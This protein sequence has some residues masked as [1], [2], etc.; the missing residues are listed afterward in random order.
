MSVF[1]SQSLR[2]RLM[3]P[4]SIVVVAIIALIS[5]VL[6]VS[7]KRSFNTVSAS[8][9]TQADVVKS[10][11]QEDL[12]GVG[13]RE[14]QR[15]EASL[16]TKA[17][18]MAS[19]VA[20][21]APT[22]ILTFDFD[23]LDNYCRALASDPDILLAHVVNMEG[24]TLTSFRNEQDEALRALVSDIDTLS[25]NQVVAALG[26]NDSAFSVRQQINQDDVPL[27]H[28]ELFVSREG[29]REQ[30]AITNE[31][32]GNIV[33]KVD[34]A[35][36]TL[37]KGVEDQVRKS[38]LN[39]AWQAVAAGIVGI[40]ILTLSVAFLIDR[41]IIKPV[42][43]VMHIIGEMA[44]GHL[45]ERLQLRR[46]D[47]IGRMSDSIDTL[48][49]TLE[50]E[51]LGSLSKLADGDLRF[52]VSPKDG[53]DALGNALQKMS[54]NLTTTIQQIQQNASV[55]ASSSEEMSA[56]SSELAASSEQ[57]TAQAANV[58]AST[59]EIN[60]S[61]HDIK[62]IAE[63]MSQNMQRLAD[64]TKRIADEVDE[65]G[66][67]AKEGSNI[68]GKAL[69]MVNNANSIILSL[70]EAAGQIGITTATIEEITEQT[71]L[72][73]L[74]ATIEAARAG[75]AGKGFAVV[76]GEVK[77]LAKQSADAA[78][79]ISG[80]IK[81][82]QDKTENAAKAIIEV[83]GII[84]QLNESSQV[85]TSAVNSHSQET[86]GMLSIVNE[87]KAAT[88]EVTDSIVS[89]AAGANEVAANI[90][91]VSKGMEDSSR[92]I[93]QINASSEELAQLATQLQ[94]LVDKFSLK[95]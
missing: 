26:T 66:N 72:L 59:E 84:K 36:L 29:I 50:Q 4:I 54:A 95:T 27:G 39:S 1:R 11:L 31:A 25:I 67:K 92:G 74:N 2:T 60:V 87:S 24:D 18:S 65:I 53:Q 28:I 62:L 91:G 80:L 8:V 32:F 52:Q 37:N 55:L 68:S 93:R 15:T 63:K 78:D 20:G 44:K 40:V 22:V 58:A 13:E 46:S 49:D 94:E 89:L 16:K 56:I 75:D 21:L 86:D 57:S 81:D 82:V 17:E 34:S 85:I 90:Q 30:T 73:A 61:S 76:A 10:S 19:L 83:S 77:E 88:N 12:R 9:A 38:M 23:V 69:D 79:N 45:S 70:Q 3:V 33:E 35:F 7:E 43:S 51:V 48:C 64:V 14:V 47:E 71:K 6:I 5:L 42:S 41:L